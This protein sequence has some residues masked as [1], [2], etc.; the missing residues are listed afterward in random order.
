MA[1]QIE[2]ARQMG[3]V[4]SVLVDT[5]ARVQ[6]LTRDVVIYVIPDTDA[7]IHSLE[8]RLFNVAT[9]RARQNTFIICPKNVTGYTYMSAEVRSFLNRL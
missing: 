7:K 3:K 1:L 2:V 5:V 6:G 4:N 9:S 8:L